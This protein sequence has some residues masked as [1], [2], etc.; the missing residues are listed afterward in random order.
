[1]KLL[2]LKWVLL[3]VLLL[4][5]VIGLIVYLNVNR[6]VRRT[7]ETQTTSSL[8]LA[9][10]LGSADLSLLGGSLAL[11]DLQIASPQGFSSPQLFAMQRAAV[12]VSYGQLRSEPIHIAAVTLH[13]PKLVVEQSGGKFNVQAAMDQMPK[14]SSESMRMIIDT[15]DIADATVTLRPGLPGLASDITVP[16]PSISLQNIGTGEG[17]QNGVAMKQVVMQVV[18]AM[19]DKAKESDKIPAE[20]RQWLNL[21]VNQLAGQL[22]D[23][24]TKQLGKNLPGNLG[25]AVGEL[26]KDPGKASEKSDQLLQQGLQGLLD[27]GKKPATRP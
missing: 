25:G 8:N 9:T 13:A 7:V 5:V 2:K 16:L 11:N 18:T 26:I 24:F 6:I 19:A 12:K 27:K 21:N 4:L 3:G 1:M 20:L 15:L 10:T 14:S 23:Q 17:N 22:G